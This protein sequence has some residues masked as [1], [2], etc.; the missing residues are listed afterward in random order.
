MPT[1]CHASLIRRAGSGTL[2][3]AKKKPISVKPESPLKEATTKMQ[4]NGYSRLPVM[5]SDWDVSGIV[6][7]E[8][9]GRRLALGRECSYVH[10]CME[11][12]EVVP[13]NTRLFDAVD[14]VSIYGYVLVRGNEAKEKNKITG[15]VTAKDLVDE[16][17]KLA[18]PFLLIG[19]I[20]SHLRNLIHGKFTLEQLQAASGEDRSIEGA[21]DLTFGGYHRLLEN[22]ENWERLNLNIDRVEF[23]RCLDAVRII[24]NE[25]MHFNPDGL[26]VDQRKTLRNVA[27]F[28]DQLS[29]LVAS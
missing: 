24:R 20:E 16:F 15:I 11:R 17:G 5:K 18:R 14:K 29:R 7:W 10:H 2:D 23:I 13:A 4:I 27:R 28:F 21:A 9:I 1:V 3:A 22:K 6:T 19:E 12:A 25:V 8:S 26:D